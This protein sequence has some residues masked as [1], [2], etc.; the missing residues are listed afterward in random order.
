MKNPTEEE[1]LGDSEAANMRHHQSLQ[2]LN[3]DPNEPELDEEGM[4]N[5]PH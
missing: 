2:R 5:S 1:E 4:V 3:R